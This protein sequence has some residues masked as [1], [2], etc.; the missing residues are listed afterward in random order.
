M[1]PPQP[2]KPA[3]EHR[4]HL[5]GSGNQEVSLGCS[6]GWE[7]ECVGWSAGPGL[8]HPC[9]CPGCRA[10]PSL[11]GGAAGRCSPP[12]SPTE[13]F[14]CPRQGAWDTLNSLPLPRKARLYIQVCFCLLINRLGPLEGQ[15]PTQAGCWLFWAHWPHPAHLGSTPCQALWLHACW[16]CPYSGTS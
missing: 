16:S 11:A 9:W 5:K 10:Q 6:E 7:W 12:G 15:P 1:W 8:T 3:S 4:L 2:A 13:V 14:V